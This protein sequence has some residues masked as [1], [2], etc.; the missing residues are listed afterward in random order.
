MKSILLISTMLFFFTHIYSQIQDII[1]IEQKA[2]QAEKVLHPKNALLDNY[3]VCFYFIDLNATNQNKTISGKASIKAK[4]VGQQLSEVMLQLVSSLTVDSVFVNG[5]N[6]A[7]TH[8]NDEIHVILPTAIDVDQ[9]FTTDVYYHGTSSGIGIKNGQ[10]PSWGAKIT[11]TLS[12]SYHAMDWFPC[13]QELTDKADSAWI[14]ITCPNTLK[15]GSNG[16]LKNTV[17]LPNNMVRYEWKTYYPIDYYLISFTISDYQEHI[18][19]AHPQGYNDSILIQ[20]YVYNNSGY[21]PYYQAQID[22]TKPFVELLSDLYGLYPYAQEKYGHCTAP[23]GGG[24]EH[25]TM[26]TLSSFS[27]ELIIHE[28]GHQWFGDYVTCANWQDI[29]VNEGFATYTYYLGQQY[30]MTQNDADN[31]M[32]GVHNDI[33][34]QPNG[35]IY[36]PFNDVNDENRIFDYRLTYEK[37][38]AIIHT[39]RH[40]INNDSIF[41]GL[42]KGFLQQ[43]AYSTAIGDDFKNYANTYTGIDFNTFFDEWYYGEGYPTYSIIW[44]QVNDTIHFSLNSVSSAPSITPFFHLPVEI[45]FS[46]GIQDT[47]IRFEHQFNNQN[48][49]AYLPFQAT[50]LSIDPNNYIVNKVGTIISSTENLDFPQTNIYPNP[51]FDKL[52]VS[53][54]ENETNFKIMDLFGRTIINSKTKGEISI[55]ELKSGIYIIEINNFRQKFVKL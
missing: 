46:N 8:T 21:L 27:F 45:K 43:H 14:F 42:L 44:N 12:E 38:A 23:I 29:W 22:N 5:Q 13:K 49:S 26:T 6:F 18:Q 48:F 3:D 31:W 53:Y 51:A 50:Q 34:A 1:P 4:V 30:L 35:S 55:S 25:Q 19:Y 24:M 33:M 41:F 28:L 54:H 2:Y 36:I 47:I 7:F 15:V 11:W 32:V 37:G 17:S 16:L 40:I 39:I 9:Y 20:H 10:S 52:F